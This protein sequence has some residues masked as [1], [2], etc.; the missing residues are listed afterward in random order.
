MDWVETKEKAVHFY[1]V[2]VTLYLKTELELFYRL[3]IFIP[4]ALMTDGKCSKV[5][6]EEDFLIR[7]SPDTHVDWAETKTEEKLVRFVESDFISKQIVGSS[8]S[9]DW[10]SSKTVMVGKAFSLRRHMDWRET[11]ETS[12][13]F[14]FL[15]YILKF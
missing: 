4:T 13:S 11:K 8:E 5:N 10:G 2:R 7:I 15:L 1:C 14:I 6:F 9:L 3:R 12:C